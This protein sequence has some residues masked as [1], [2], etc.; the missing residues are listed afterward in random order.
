VLD[1]CARQPN[2]CCDHDWYRIRTRPTDEQVRS[3]ARYCASARVRRPSTPKSTEAD[4]RSA[5]ASTRVVLSSTPDTTPLRSRPSCRLSDPVRS[6]AR[7][8]PPIIVVP[9]ATTTGASST[10]SKWQ[11]RSF[12]RKEAAQ[13]QIPRSAAAALARNYRYRVVG[14]RNVVVRRGSGNA[15]CLFA[16]KKPAQR[17][18]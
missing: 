12:P 9:I 10:V 15:L 13:S 1:D 18:P 2:T 4:L 11:R 3:G 16:A 5:D 7:L 6:T 8:R 14:I 17:R